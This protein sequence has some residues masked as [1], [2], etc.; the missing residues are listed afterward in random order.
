[1][2]RERVRRSDGADEIVFVYRV[3]GFSDRTF[4]GRHLHT[5]SRLPP[6]EAGSAR[7]SDPLS[8]MSGDLH[9]RVR[10]G[11]SRL[12]ENPYPPCSFR[13]RLRFSISGV[14]SRPFRKTVNI[15]FNG[16]RPPVFREFYFID[17]SERFVLK[18]RDPSF[19]NL[20]NNF[21][22]KRRHTSNR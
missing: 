10:L 11:L 5:R 16:V 7:I 12:G 9:V 22:E 15:G 1:M 19:S 17:E 6:Y 4:T 20:K 3:H 13:S 8:T 14:R 21:H 18:Y 2:A